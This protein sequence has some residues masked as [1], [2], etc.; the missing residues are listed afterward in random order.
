MTPNSF[1][2]GGELL[3]ANTLV[4]RLKS[5]Q[6]IPA[7]FYDIGAESTA[8]MNAAIGAEAE[9][10]RIFTLLPHLPTDLKYSLDSYRAETVRKFIKERDLSLWNDVSGQLDDD[11]L[12]VLSD[13]PKLQSVY[14]HSNAPTRELCN[15][16]MDYVSSDDIYQQV[17]K[18]FEQALNW[19]E[20]NNLKQPILDPCLGFSKSHEQNWQLLKRLPRFI[21]SFEASFGRQQW[22]LGV[23]RKSFFKRLSSEKVDHNV[24]LQTEYMQTFYLAWLW[25]ELGEHGQITVRLHDP[26]LAY[27]VSQ[28]G[29]LL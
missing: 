24:R 23:S 27:A 3:E 13:F 22:L 6:E 4:Q 20:K 21:T 7:K 16:H 26:A 9:W 19:Y 2:D 11:L 28:V 12:S 14:C 5:W 18:S 25:R 10:A 29:E 8:P 1:S 15:K 17:W